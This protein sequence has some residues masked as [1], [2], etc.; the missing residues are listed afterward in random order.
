L[1]DSNTQSL[2]ET[3]G[4]DVFSKFML[5][6]LKFVYVGVRVFLRL[7]LGKKRRDRIYSRRRIN[8]KDFL[9]KSIRLLRLYNFVLLELHIV[10]HNYKVCCRLNKEDLV[11]STIHEED[12]IME[13]FTPKKGDAVV[14]LGANIGRY[15]IIASNRV[16]PT[17]KVVAIEAHPSNFKILKKNI[18]LNRLANVIP[19]N[20]AVSS[21][22]TKL[23][24]Y[25]PDE[26]L[27]YT[28][29]HSIMFNYLLPRFETKTGKEYVEV[30]A[31]TLD[32]LLQ[33]NRIEQV[34]WIKIDVEGAEF[35]VLKG[36]HNVL[37]KSKDIVLIVEI[38]GSADNNNYK[39]IIDLLNLYNFKIEFE[40]TYHG[41]EVHKH[42]I[43]RKLIQ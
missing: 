4:A 25:T 6:S 28:M 8:F 7:A 19:L 37:S 38:H 34:N 41:G 39:S 29:H 3:R 1:I 15:A 30:K 20:Y 27:G 23:K 11:A 42:V 22:E 31:N 12:M 5:S 32:N 17:G 2:R 10:K 40:K 16:G 24:L 21:S 35:E 33:Q 43:V 26:E 36:A 13:H 9:Y 14:D 18:E